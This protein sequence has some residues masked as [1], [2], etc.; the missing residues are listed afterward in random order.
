MRTQH[1]EEKRRRLVRLV[2]VEGQPAGAAA[3]RLGVRPST[4]YYWIRKAAVNAPAP[5][6]ASRAEPPAEAAAPLTPVFAR[7]VRSE[8]KAA[9]TSLELR[10]GGVTV[11]VR[12][13]FDA[14]LLRAV[15]EA[16]TE[17]ST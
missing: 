1:T 9:A 12:R 14:A 4:A 7:L 2:T 8:E 11:V 15:V 3:R 6:L 5:A 10:I 16:L 17:A 13:G